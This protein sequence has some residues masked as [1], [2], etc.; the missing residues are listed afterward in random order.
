MLDARLRVYGECAASLH[1]FARATYNR[2]KGR[3]EEVPDEERERR[4]QE[5]YRCNARARAAIGQAA[6]LSRNENLEK[7]LTEARR[8]IGSMTEFRDAE[9]LTRRQREVFELVEEALRSARSDLMR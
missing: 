9:D 4:R 6:I 3:L 7:Q 2:A 5:A 1:E 8:G